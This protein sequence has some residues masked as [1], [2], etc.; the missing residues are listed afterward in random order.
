M[1]EFER[2]KT[3]VQW[4]LGNSCNYNCSY[5]LDI[6]KRGDIPFIENE[7]LL[8]TCKDIIYHYDS[9]GRDVVF[10]F[11][12]GEPTLIEKIPDIANR[13]HNFPTNIIL[14]TNGSADLEWWK[15]TRRYLTEVIIS[16]HKEFADIK[17]IK[18]VINLLK[19]D[20]DSH[21]VDVKLLFPVTQRS[22]SWDWGVKQVKDFRKKY[23]LGDLQLLYSNFGRGSDTYLPYNENQWK[24]YKKLTHNE[25]TEEKNDS[26]SENFQYKNIVCH[27][28][29]EILVIDF[30]GNVFRGWCMQG[31]KIGNIKNLPVN[32]P[33]DTIIC[34]KDYCNNGFDRLAKKELTVVR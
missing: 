30:L 20:T 16:V 27:A 1:D 29:I 3:K 4:M 23:G 22:D 15:K 28:G 14:R 18:K 33:V 8:E 24:V 21:P 7:L 5:C 13:L 19:D 9:L 10:E 6:F 11:I 31:G 32:Y 34:G 25:I 26:V 2:P 12:G 17:H